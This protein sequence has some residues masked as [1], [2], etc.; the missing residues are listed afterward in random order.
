[1]GEV[2]L[3]EDTK[4]NRKVALK[5]LPLDTI[6]NQEQI[7]RFL[8]E[9][10]AAAKLHHENIAHIYEIDEA[11]GKS[12]IAMEYVEG[13]ALDTRI[14]GRPIETDEIIR[15]GIDTAAALEEAHNA[16]ITHRDIKPSNIM[17]T[18][19]GQ[20]KVLDFGLAKVRGPSSGPTPADAPTQIKT[21]PGVVL[22]TLDY[23][24][25]EQALGREVDHRSDIFSLGLTLYE[26]ATGKRPFTGATAPETLDRIL[27]AQPAPIAQSNDSVPAELERIIGKCL[28]K[29]R[30]SRYQ[31]AREL[32]TD[33]RNLQ[34]GSNRP[35][36]L[37]DK[38]MRQEPVTVRRLIY[39]LLALA[40]LAVVGFVIFRAITRNTVIDSVAVLPFT[41]ASTDPNLEYLSDGIT[42]NLINRL[43]QLPDLRVVPRSTVFR[44][45]GQDVDPRAAARSLGVRAVIVGKVE[46]R[47]DVL[48]IQTELIDVT[49]EAQLWGEQYNR[50]VTDLLTTQEEI[51]TAIAD[52]LRHRLSE[53][54]RQRLTKRDTENTEAYQLYLRGRYFWNKRTESGMQKGI[55]YFRKAI[56]QDP[57]YSLAHVGLAD[58]YNFLGAFGIAVMPPS[59]AMPKAKLAAMNALKIDDSLAEA[60]TSLAFVSLYYDWN[61]SEAEKEFRRA[62]E[63]RPSYAP[64]HQWYS[65]YLMV[66]GQTS[67]SLAEAK[68]AV[69]IDPLSLPA[70]MNLGWQYHW[71]RQYDL[72]VEHLL[73]PL[74]MDPNFEQGHWGIGLAY[75]LKGMHEQ[76]AAEFQKAVTLS[77]DN[78]VYLAALGHAYAIGG[79][80]VAATKVHK[81]LEKQSKV[82]YVPP[83]WMATLYAGLGEKDLA[84]RWLEKAYEERSGGMIWLSVDPR[85]DSLR[86]DPRF[87]AMMQRVGIEQK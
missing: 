31:S 57:T 25:P 81:E 84:F 76:A 45:R 13:E 80:K 14:K 53:T 4:L 15:I 3:A 58:S 51:A 9:A 77:G 62:I 21:S 71:A 38:S 47:G 87:A 39:V 27:H 1:M 64:A 36:V 52:K 85:M 42:E 29:D 48:S 55:E 65:H 68:R 10:R 8:Q 79:N 20:V 72:A 41:D 17:L 24:S 59:E 37:T 40:I 11:D 22:G 61:W 18:S 28:E 50:R 54:E 82:R 67:E 44:Y 60:H 32:L 86:T 49:N 69:E 5:F 26:M 16:G 19:R 46:Q 6:P 33:L 75:E 73:K 74:E 23:M 43:S 83:Y 2:Y 34:R 7:L 78:P 35:L 30:E 12:F 63:L 66:R 56:E 70:N